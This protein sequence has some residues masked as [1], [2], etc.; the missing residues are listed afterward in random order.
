MFYRA[1][2]EQAKDIVSTGE[3]LPV[4]I[5]KKIVFLSLSAQQHHDFLSNL[6]F[7]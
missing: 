4:N 7:L 5:R 3:H 1:V 2:K 6:A